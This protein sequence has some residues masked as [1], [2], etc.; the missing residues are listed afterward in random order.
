MRTTTRR[1]LLA[2]LTKLGGIAS[3]GWLAGCR[4]QSSA[5]PAPRPYR[6]GM[7]A[8]ATTPEEATRL[9]RFNAFWDRM[10]ELGYAEG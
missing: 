6:V 10:A 3:L 4:S 9:A 2:N 7:L 8:A 1:E 5:A